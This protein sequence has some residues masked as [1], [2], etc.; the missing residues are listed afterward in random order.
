MKRLIAAGMS[1]LLA[2]GIGTGGLW[3]AS[4]ASAA[5]EAVAYT[6]NSTKD[7]WVQG[8]ANAN[9]VYGT[10]DKMKVKRTST[11][12]R[13]AFLQFDAS[14]VT[15]QVY[16]AELR[17]YVVSMESA[18][19]TGG[20]QYNLEIRGMTDDN[21]SEDTMTYAT[22]PADEGQIIGTLT[23]KADH[24]GSYIGID[25]SEY[26]TAQSDSKLSFRIRGVESSKGADY[27]AKE[28]QNAPQ[29]V[30]M[31]RP[32]ST[33]DTQPPTVPGSVTAQQLSSGS[34]Q[35]SWNASS[36]N[37]GT[38]TYV[39]YRND[40]VRGQTQ[41][42]VYT[43]EGLTPGTTYTYRV[44]AVDPSGNMSTA[45]ENATVTT[46]GQQLVSTASDDSYTRTGSGPFGSATTM[47]VKSNSSG[48]D[49]RRAYLKFS[50]PT[51]SGNLESAV[52]KLYVT[53]LESSTPADGYDV[54][55]YGIQ[56]DAWSEA[57]LTDVNRPQE[58]G[59]EIGQVRVNSDKAGSYIEFDAAEFVRG[60]SD[61]VASFY[62]E[63]TSR[64]SR[65][66]NY[67][68]KENSINQPP[69]L[70]LGVVPLA[71]PSV[72][73]DVTVAA[74]SKRVELSWSK[75]THASIYRVYRSEGNDFVLLGETT[76]QTYTDTT[77]LNDQTY[78][79]KIK[80]ANDAFESDWSEAVTT[81]PKYPLVVREVQFQN[82]DGDAITA[83][84]GHAFVTMSG[85]LAS[86]SA[87]THMVL[88]RLRLM[89]I[90]NGSDVQVAATTM[91]SK[92]KPD[93]SVSFEWSIQEGT[94]ENGHYFELSVLDAQGDGTQELYHTRQY[95][96]E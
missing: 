65:G 28:G 42:L 50:V 43:E 52:V 18:T 8:G 34:V 23:V 40:A 82:L 85:E 93:A 44:H 80:A 55:L 76:G 15:G 47:N 21:W 74:A 59:V 72:P 13:D 81:T 70:V 1:F 46:A 75:S 61:G 54:T 57:D 67:A 16:A 53:G 26:V 6:L 14:T 69:V 66:A 33:T 19:I 31:A 38:V 12:N 10:S 62:L 24:V 48:T 68:T 51:Y 95:G 25:V 84:N 20:G 3:S 90:A 63:S 5:E 88:L 79:Y 78:S 29:L 45:S 64:V 22:T 73:A 7:T 86:L 27:G 39:V 41:E 96:N 92:V 91:Q 56:A 89:K 58:V 32:A 9:T 83:L 71:T 94:L 17:L 77:V 2:A 30:L 60:Q 11:E 87:D 49:I 35:V 37:S 4:P 36:D